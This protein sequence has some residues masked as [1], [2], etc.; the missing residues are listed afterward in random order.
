MNPS[1]VDPSGMDPIRVALRQDGSHGVD[2]TGVDP[3]RADPPAVSPR[4]PH[5]PA[6]SPHP[7]APG[8]CAAAPPGSRREEAEGSE[9]PSGFIPRLPLPLLLLHKEPRAPQARPPRSN[10][11][12][13][14]LFATPSGEPGAF[15]GASGMLLPFRATQT[16]WIPCEHGFFH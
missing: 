13:L 10:F 16:D 15:P 8:G 9:H 7:A 11:N 4:Y 14:N 2:P 12:F 5:I 3:I 6:A 1:G